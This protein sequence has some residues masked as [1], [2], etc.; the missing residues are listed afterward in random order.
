[1]RW[2]YL[3]QRFDMELLGGFVGVAQD[4]GTL[5]LRPE[6]GW[7]VREAPPARV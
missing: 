6:V 5:C 3:H 1:M 7:V 2:E 4:G